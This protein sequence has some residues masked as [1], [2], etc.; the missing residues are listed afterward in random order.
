MLGK[1]EENFTDSNSRKANPKEA[2]SIAEASRVGRGKERMYHT[3]VIV[4]GASSFF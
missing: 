2:D 1:K 3:R 4:R